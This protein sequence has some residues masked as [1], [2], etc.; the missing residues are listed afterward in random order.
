M[1]KINF[2]ILVCLLPLCMLAQK[3]F[4]VQAI[5][6]GL[7]DKKVKFTYTLKNKTVFDTVVAKTKDKIIWTGFTTEP[8]FVRMDILDSSLNLYVGK[9]VAF[10]PSLMF[11]LSN[12]VINIKGNPK[13][14]YA[15]SINSPDKTV[16]TYEK[17]RK[18]DIPVTRELWALQKKQNSKANAKDSTG[19]AAIK[20]SISML[21]KKNQ[22]ARAVFVEKNPNSFAS[23]LML[24]SLFLI[25]TAEDLSAKYEA[26]P[27]SI[28]HS[29]T[30]KLVEEKIESKRNTANGKPV[31]EFRQTGYDGQVVDIAELKGKVIL[32]D[33]WG[34]WCVPCRMSH[35]AMKDLY[36]E[37]KSR[38]FEIVGISN[39]MPGIER[40][41]SV[42]DSLWRKAIVADGITWKN[43]LYD[44]SKT[45]L[46]K[47]YDINGYPTKF[48]ID[49]QGKFVLKLSGNS[50][51]NHEA[52][53]NKLKEL[54]PE[55][56]N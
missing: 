40:P 36:K 1:K 43:V 7:G 13:E 15:A 25:L 19:V 24:N 8:Q 21:R 54:L 11:V 39:E 32:I 2:C 42:Q 16:M 29:T 46:V 28:K 56:Q 50:P 53:L 52:L 44:P 41:K 17:F 20:D 12:G 9:A 10:P 51:Q 47:M 49:Q 27:E 30:G 23:L 31:M 34:S 4:T 48:L 3:G 38:G 33:F 45:N 14:L 18:S 26:F 22:K 37:F 5:L 35:P 55:K 6:P